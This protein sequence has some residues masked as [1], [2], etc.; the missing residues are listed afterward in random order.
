MANFCNWF[1]DSLFGVYIGDVCE[2]HDRRYESTRLTKIQADK[3]LYREIRRK[4]LPN[5]ARVM[6][7]GVSVIGWVPY[8]YWW[9]KTGTHHD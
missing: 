2:R 4:G 1:P 7:I 9:I 6:F 5:T 8:Y 3:L